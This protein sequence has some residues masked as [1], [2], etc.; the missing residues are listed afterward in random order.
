MDPVTGAIV[1]ALA[2]GVAS[3]AGEVGKKIVVDAYDALKAAIRQK[4]GIESEVAKAVDALEKKPDSE[5]RKATLREEVETTQLHKD[6]EV[7]KLAETLLEQVK[8]QPGGA[9]IV[10]QATGSYIAQA[11]QGSTA[12]VNVDRSEQQS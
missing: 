10:Q 1:A 6:P 11:A 8:A 4:L 12:S 9:Q 5:G 7:L 2:A 3:S